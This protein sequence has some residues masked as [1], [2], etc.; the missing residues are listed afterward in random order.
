MSWSIAAARSSRRSRSP[1]AWTPCRSSKSCVAKRVDLLRVRLV[2]VV[3]PPEAR[4]GVEH[5]LGLAR[6][7]P[8]VEELVDELLE[9]A[10]REAHARGEDGRLVELLG[11]AQEDG[12]RGHDGV[13]AVG[14]E[15][16]RVAALAV[17]HARTSS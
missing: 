1:K 10:R 6:G 16:V 12:R 5:A 15:L 11:E 9:D 14:P 3:V 7:V 13:R 2:E 17:R 8:D 4:A